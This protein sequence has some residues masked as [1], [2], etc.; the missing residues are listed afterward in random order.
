MGTGVATI[1]KGD[2]LS[3]TY[4]SYIEL[5]GEVPWNVRSLEVLIYGHVHYVE[6]LAEILIFCYCRQSTRRDNRLDTWPIQELAPLSSFN[7]LGFPA[8][9]GINLYMIR[10]K[11]TL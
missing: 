2:P 7:S 1:K 9:I 5:C 6:L 10:Y 3:R 4:N 8:G 11:R